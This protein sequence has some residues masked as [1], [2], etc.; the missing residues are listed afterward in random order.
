MH[1]HLCY[2]KYLAK[3]CASLLLLG[4]KGTVSCICTQYYKVKRLPTV[5]ATKFT[6]IPELF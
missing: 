5:I 6:I 3:E 2:G 1:M 4:R